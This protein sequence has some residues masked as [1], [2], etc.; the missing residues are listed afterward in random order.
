MGEVGPAQLMSDADRIGFLGDTHGDLAHVLA[1]SRTMSARGI[2]VL[3]VLGD[4]G[5]IWPGHNWD[6]DIDKLS[7][8]LA[9]RQQSLYFVDG[10]HEDFPRLYRF[11]VTPDGLRWIR[12]NIAHIPRGHRTTLVSGKTLA[13]LG[14]ANSVDVGHRVTGRSWW[15]AESITETD[16]AVLGN[17][18]AD[19]LIGHDAP[20]HVPSLDAW[21]AET[22][23]WWPESGLRYAEAGRTMFHRGFMQVR[24]TLYLGG[25][26]HRHIDE[27]VHYDSGDDRFQ[28][29]VVILD[30]NG[31]P[32]TISQLILETRTLGVEG[33]TQEDHG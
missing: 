15:P 7:Q 12:P 20:K 16:L 25:H 32:A 4:F 11:P 19:I 33:F 27:R 6:N 26:Y 8:R 22:N 2:R 10:N 5:F 9:A 24:P 17:D 13:A 3:V 30:Q 1:V 31:S 21:L 14:G 29:R 28:S 23:R 18:H